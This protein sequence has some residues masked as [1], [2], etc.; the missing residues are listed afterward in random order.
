MLSLWH[1]GQMIPRQDGS[2]G[3]K[4]RRATRRLV[5]GWRIWE[6]PSP[7]PGAGLVYHEEEKSQEG[8]HDTKKN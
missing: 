1:Y 7:V 6:N 8:N 5:G 3:R 2:S 4:L